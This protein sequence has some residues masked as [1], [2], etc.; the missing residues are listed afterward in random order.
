MKKRETR[1]GVYFREEDESVSE[2]LQNIVEFSRQQLKFK[3][4]EVEPKQGTKLPAYVYA[5]TLPGGTRVKD[6][7]YSYLTFKSKV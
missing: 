7:K 3:P 1:A 4:I 2:N 6:V 5:G